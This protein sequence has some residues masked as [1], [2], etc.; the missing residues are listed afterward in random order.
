[1]RK[2]AYL[3]TRKKEK[4]APVA[5]LV[6]H[7]TLNQG[8]Q[9]SSPCGCTKSLFKLFFFAP[10]AQLVE[11]L[12]LNQGVQGSSPCGCT[13]REASHQG[14]LLFFFILTFYIIVMQLCTPRLVAIAVSIAASVCKI[15]FHVSFFIAFLFLFVNNW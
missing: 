11:H 15:N 5:Q 14:L 6:E 13:A 1:M 2:N 9:G 4:D 3:C 8:V 7:L 12:T 10:V